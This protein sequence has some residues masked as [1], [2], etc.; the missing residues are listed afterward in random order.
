MPGVRRR[1]CPGNASTTQEM[2]TKH[3]RRLQRRYLDS[4]SRLLR[5]IDARFSYVMPVTLR[6]S[7]SPVR[8]LVA[9]E[10]PVLNLAG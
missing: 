1:H 8:I 5:R 3:P 7:S 4:D 10:L 6:H 9:K 2:H